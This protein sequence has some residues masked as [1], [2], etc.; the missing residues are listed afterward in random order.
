MA[1]AGEI[2]I[3]LRHG[4][5]RLDA[6]VLNEHH[7]VPSVVRVGGMLLLMG[8]LHGLNVLSLPVIGRLFSLNRRLDDG[9]DEDAARLEV[10]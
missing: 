3:V 6:A 9:G 1:E 8:L 7:E 10:A 4:E 5:E 2:G